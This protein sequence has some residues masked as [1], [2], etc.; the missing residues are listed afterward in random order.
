MYV[1][2]RP[3]PPKGASRSYTGILTTTSILACLPLF[4]HS[5]ALI[6]R[7]GHF[8]M[9]LASQQLCVLRLLLYAMVPT[10]WDKNASLGLILVISLIHGAN[11]ALFWSA[12]VDTMYLLSG[13]ILLLLLVFSYTSMI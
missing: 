2:K 4:Y 12:V 11:F 10:H 6:A 1:S 3:P 13:T 7:Y 9:I 8:K 5:D